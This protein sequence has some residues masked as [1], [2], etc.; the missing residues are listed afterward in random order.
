MYGHFTAPAKAK[1]ATLPRS[2]PCFGGKH[3]APSRLLHTTVP[4]RDT[5]AARPSALPRAAMAPPERV[6]VHPLVLLSTVDHY[7]R[8]AKARGASARGGDA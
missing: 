8:V 3:A 2:R 7:T 4:P 6:V 5:S 1:Q